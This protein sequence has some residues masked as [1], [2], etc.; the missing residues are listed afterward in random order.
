MLFNEAPLNNAWNLL[1][2][3]TEDTVAFKELQLL[4]NS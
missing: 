3:D 1:D 4:H 2:K